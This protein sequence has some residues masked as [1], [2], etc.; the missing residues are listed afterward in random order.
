[1]ESDSMGWNEATMRAICVF[2]TALT[3]TCSG[4]AL[5]PPGY[6][7]DYATVGGKWERMDPTTGRVGSILSDPGLNVAGQSMQEDVNEWDVIDSEGSLEPIPP[8]AGDSILEGS[9]ASPQSLDVS[10]PSYETQ[11][12]LTPEHGLPVRDGEIILGET[13]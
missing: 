8:A 1:M 7:D 11:L 4:C 10:P 13:W 5:C 3:M 9:G 6:L 12:E 2:L